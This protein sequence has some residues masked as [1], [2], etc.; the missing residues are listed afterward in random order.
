MA[1]M[2]M[3]APLALVAQTVPYQGKY[4]VDG[5]V[6]EKQYRS[7]AALESTAQNQSSVLV[8]NAGQLELIWMRIHKTAGGRT[9]NVSETPGLNASVLAV[10]SS[11]L[12]L[13]NC[14]VSSHSGN[15]DVIAVVG[16]GSS[17]S[18]TKGTFQSSRSYSPVFSS[19]EGGKIMV[20][21]SNA[22]SEDSQSPLVYSIGDGST[23][24]VNGVKGHTGG[25]VSPVFRGSG[26]IFANDC[27]I[28]SLA[29]NY[30]IIEESGDISIAD[31]E[32]LEAV[33]GAILARNTQGVPSDKPSRLDIQA[34]KINVKKGDLIS[35]VNCNSEIVLQKNNISI[36]KGGAFIRAYDDAFGEKGKNGG[37][38]KVTLNKQAVIGNVYVNSISSAVIELGKGSTL[39]GAVNPEGKGG[40]V[41]IYLA[42]G[43]VWA[44][45]SKSD[46]TVIR[47]EQP[48]E[49]GVKQIKSKGDIS[50]DPRD[51]ANA[52]LGGREFKL[53]GGGFL[54][55][56]K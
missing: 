4:V 42:K 52:P 9:G 11:Q 18:I 6:Q 3:N 19:F 40:R 31:C 27:R 39:K 33:D 10:G 12:T 35:A 30:V 2:A 26:T 5:K 43:A 29:S 21:Q 46:I 48:V 20:D 37:H 53:A 15:S 28:S 23:V 32:L 1:V 49:K 7:R 38:V 25:I 14:T 24:L 55:P 50:Y 22:M 16:N 54:R 41:E 8:S 44:S 36:P 47:F 13:D 45:D 56:V 17:A 51:P 34:S